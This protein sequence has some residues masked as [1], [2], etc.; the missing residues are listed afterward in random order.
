MGRHG[1]RLGCGR[2]NGNRNRERI[3][4]DGKADPCLVQRGILSRA[5]HRGR[6]DG[7]DGA[8][9]VIAAD[10]YRAADDIRRG[11][12]GEHN[13]RTRCIY[14]VDDEVGRLVEDRRDGVWHDGDGKANTRLVEGGILGPATDERRS[15][16]EDRARRVI[17]GDQHRPADIIHSGRWDERDR[18]AGEINR[19]DDEVDRLVEDRRHGIERNG[20]FR[21]DQGL[22]AWILASNHDGVGRG[23]FR[24]LSQRHNRGRRRK[25]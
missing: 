14:R 5:S 13:R 24:L 3:D 4:G 10:R 11:R 25:G 6:A 23:R 20:G 19:V 8:G 18:C 16:G 15:D 12:Y 7:E 1:R 21:L 2:R 9:R 17:A 22:R